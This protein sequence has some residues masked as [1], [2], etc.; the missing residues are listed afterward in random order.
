[1]NF[2]VPNSNEFFTYTNGLDV[3][4]GNAKIKS[5]LFWNLK[6]GTERGIYVKDYSEAA[7]KYF[8]VDSGYMV[9]SISVPRGRV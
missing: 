1:M 2:L 8:E 9:S 4:I 7:M 6:E 3:R 5:I